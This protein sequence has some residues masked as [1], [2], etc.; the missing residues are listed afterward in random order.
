VTGTA[1]DQLN[2]LTAAWWPASMMPASFRDQLSGLAAGE[3]AWCWPIRHHDRFWGGIIIFG[4]SPADGDESY[5]ALSDSIG[6]WFSA[7][8]AATAA[9][10]LNE[11]VVEMNRRLIASQAEVARMRSLSMTGAMAAGAAHELNNPLAVISGRAQLLMSEEQGDKVQRAAATISE[12]AHRA[13][14]IVSELMEFAKPDPPEPTDWSVAE[15]LGDLRRSWIEKGVFTEKQFQLR[16]SDDLPEIR[17]DASQIAKLFDE[18]IRNAAE[19]MD[20]SDNPLLTINCTG[21]VTDD[22]VVI[23]VTDNGCGMSASV[24]EEAMTPFFSHRTAGRGRGLG[25]SRA[26]RYAEI[27]N[28]RLR[29]TSRENEGTVVLIE[30]PIVG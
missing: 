17:A 12:N 29:L 1:I 13:S 7:A 2:E 4:E 22:K 27:N 21:H 14:G 30:L 19:A 23:E 16:L 9:Q 3:A 20:K 25:L 24:L 28:A 8:E 26:V 10:K 18:V 6:A 15:L 11:E 5:A